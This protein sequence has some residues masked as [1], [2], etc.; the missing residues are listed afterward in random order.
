MPYVSAQDLIDRIGED[1]VYVLADR[2]RDGALDT[3]TI[4]EAAADAAAE[5]DAYLSTR[6]DVPLA[7]VPRVIKRLAVDM[8]IYRLADAAGGYTEERRKRYEDAIA[9][10]RRIA[11]GEVGLGIPP[12][13]DGA[14][15]KQVDVVGDQIAAESNPPRLFTRKTQR[16]L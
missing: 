7:P 8:A 1:A 2:D 14:D 6:Y 15:D 9:L 3:A 12:A 16:G 13:G 11:S 5:I 4:D 10:L